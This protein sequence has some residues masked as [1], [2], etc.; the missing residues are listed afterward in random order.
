MPTPQPNIL[1]IMADQLAARSLKAYGHPLVKTPHLDRLAQEGVAFDNAYT[2]SP[3]CAPA[4]AA[5]MN[6]LL[7]S[8]SGVYDNAAEFPSAI[9][10][11]A[12]Y[13]RIA[14]YRTSLSGKM[15]FVGPD[16][17]HGLEER[18]TTDIYPADFGWT[19]D[20]RLRQERIDWWYHNMT[21]VLQPGI[22]EITNQLEFDDEVAFLATRKIYDYARYENEAPFCLM[23][24][25]TH[26]HDPYA[27]RSRFWNLYRDEDIDLPAIP[28]LAKED[29]DP[30]SRRLYEMS[31][32]GDYV[33]TE[34]DIRAARHGYY[35][36][37]SYVD[38]LIGQLMAALAATGKLHDTIIVFTSDHGD[39]L[40]ERGLWYKM[41]FLEPSAHVPLIVWSPKRFA[42]RR[43]SEPVTL[44]DLLPTFADIA[45]D[46]K[47]RFARKIDGRSLYPLLCGA[48]EDKEATAWGEY[49]AEGAVAPLYMLRRGNW[50]FIHT[51]VDPDQLFDLAVDPQERVN[52]A[53]EPRHK[54]QAQ[55]FRR[56][57]EQAFDI[58]RITGEVLESQQSRLMMFEALRRGAHFPWDFQP[59][60]QAS[61][62]YTRNH[63]SVTD[64]DLRSRFPA[65]PD[66]E[67][68][69]R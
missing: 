19:P 13:L 31:A 69:R 4:R 56:E 16:Q 40:G 67:D 48:P 64:R 11:F 6:G 38:D 66:I 42:S 41:S 29:L 45:A 39:F 46:G 18:L 63:M 3:L 55:A 20:W 34:K 50:K 17:L 21:S 49:L 23:A 52:L 25:F 53:D 26:P 8:R 2:P 33:V 22:A 10:T 47:A 60:R 1:F 57:V 44:C 58:A 12:H 9:P 54:A 5:V 30:H 24:S 68:K 59:L 32:M 43:V 62:Q 65:A 14:G 35:A 27:A 36:N 51:P 28:A 15:H 7:P 37:I 61:E